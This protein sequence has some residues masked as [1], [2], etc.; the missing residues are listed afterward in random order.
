MGKIDL[1]PR[2]IENIS[3]QKER[4][5]EMK[6]VNVPDY[7]T[8]NLPVDDLGDLIAVVYKGIDVW[9]KAKADGV[10]NGADLPH[11]IPLAMLFPALFTGSVNIIPQAKDLTDE[12][13]KTLVDKSNEYELGE[14]APKARGLVKWILVSAQTGFLF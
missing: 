6:T 12:E 2:G 9:L 4:T 13:I 7:V 11:L 14:F 1:E 3:K 5:F 10:I 8:I